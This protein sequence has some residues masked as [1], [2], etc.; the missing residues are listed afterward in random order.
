M[1]SEIELEGKVTQLL[2]LYTSIYPYLNILNF[3]KLEKP[4]YQS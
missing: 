2:S 1:F 3:V 4:S